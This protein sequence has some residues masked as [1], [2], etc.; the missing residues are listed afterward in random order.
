M[1]VKKSKPGVQSVDLSELYLKLIDDN[2]DKHIFMEKFG[3]SGVF[4]FRALGRQEYR[5]IV[6]TEELT[7]CDKEELICQICTLYPEKYDFENCD[8]AGLPTA[9]SKK[10]LE[11]SMLT[12]AKSLRA[13][14]YH[15]R[16]EMNED[17]NRQI[18]CVIHEAFPEF[19]IDGDDGIENWDIIRTAEYMARAEFI[20]HSLRGV[21][22]APADINDGASDNYNEP[23]TEVVDDSY[24]T[25][26]D[27][28]SRT[29]VT[30]K[31]INA[32]PRTA[33]TRE[34]LEQLQRIAP[35]IDWTEDLGN[36]DV[37]N[38]SKIQKNNQFD[39]RAAALIPTDGSEDGQDAI[40][41]ALRDKFKVI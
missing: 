13:L 2:P 15:F 17:Y 6:T 27:D 1:Q 11:S 14:I 29:R 24:M 37:E 12:D 28:G 21:P 39:D 32:K 41:L 8:E 33:A 22:M 25:D 30:K 26:N 20:L 40:P 7:N 35:G 3:D 38:L 23:Q 19:K 4:I 5:K 34:K 10:I 16:D 36:M 31:T 18:S 9:L